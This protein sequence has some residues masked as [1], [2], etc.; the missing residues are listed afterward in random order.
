MPTMLRHSVTP[1][2]C[3]EL[4]RPAS[5][6]RFGMRAAAGWLA[7]LAPFDS[8]PLATLCLSE[9]WRFT[10]AFLSEP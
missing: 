6:E 2:L 1:Y 9:L 5:Q 4:A 10:I 3:A 7:P 8:A